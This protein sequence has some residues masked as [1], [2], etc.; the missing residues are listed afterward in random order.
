MPTFKQKILVVN[1]DES[2]LKTVKSF[3]E[4]HPFIS[5]VPLKSAENCIGIINH[6]EI[7]LVILDYFLPDQNGLELLKTIKKRFQELPVIVILDQ[8][9]EQVTVN[10]FESGA[11]NCLTRLE[12]EGW[13]QILFL[14]VSRCLNNQFTLRKQRQLEQRCQE[15][16]ISVI[17]S[18]AALIELKDPY[19][20]GHSRIV[21]NLS[22]A[23]GKKLP[24]SDAELEQIEIAAFLH[25]IGKIGISG[26]ILN[27]PGSLTKPEYRNIQK[28]VELGFLTLTHINKLQEVSKIVRHHHE[29]YNGLGYPDGLKGEK[30]PLGSRIIHIVDAYSAM[31]SNRPY[32]PCLPEANVIAELDRNKGRDFDPSLIDIFLQLLCGNHKKE[33]K[34]HL[35]LGICLAGA[36]HQNY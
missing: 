1:K 17:S 24:L 26:K 23:I 21:R 31:S 36:N 35:L 16:L 7:D 6:D 29:A 34:D 33:Q 32:R 8:P 4:K 14:L 9:D 13:L 2:F 3:L 12:G 28:H 10:A 5:V 20:G 18:L 30:I 22:L 27:K 15:N 25:D 19:T 11:F